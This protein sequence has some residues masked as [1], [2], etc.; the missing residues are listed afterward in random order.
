MQAKLF[1]SPQKEFSICICRLDKNYIKAFQ[2]TR[3]ICSSSKINIV[4]SL[5]ERTSFVERL[6]A[7]LCG[8]KM[9]YESVKV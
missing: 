1:V 8:I 5:R 4:N 6:R 9:M 2:P 7:S 3:G